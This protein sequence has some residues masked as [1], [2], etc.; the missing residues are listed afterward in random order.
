MAARKIKKV[1]KVPFDVYLW[2]EDKTG[3]NAS[4]V[5]RVRIGKRIY[6]FLIDTGASLCFIGKHVLDGNDN[7]SKNAIKGEDINLSLTAVGESKTI[8]EVVPNL[9]FRMDS[10]DFYKDFY[11][12]DL[13]DDE[14][15]YDGIMG[16]NVLYQY[17]I[18]MNN[19]KLYLEFK[20]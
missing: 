10:V 4:P 9:C 7:V 2:G 17:Q 20:K 1:H 12:I 5:V 11:V 3:D 13:G 19:E 18:I 14:E 16:Y 6:K 15:H 8:N